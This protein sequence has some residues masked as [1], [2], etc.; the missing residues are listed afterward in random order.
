MK[1]STRTNLKAWAI[2]WLKTRTAP[3]YPTQYQQKAIAI[4]ALLSD[5]EWHNAKE[6]CKAIGLCDR[7]TRNLVGALKE[8]F[9]LA[10][11]TRRGYQMATEGSIIS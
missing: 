1:A 4:H 3:E 9:G 2:A 8:P 11:H 6:I 5:G 7:T 10:S